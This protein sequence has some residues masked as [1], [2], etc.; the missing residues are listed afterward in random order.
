MSQHPRFY[1]SLKATLSRINS[2]SSESSGVASLS[3]ATPKNLNRVVDIEEDAQSCAEVSCEDPQWEVDKLFQT[4]RDAIVITDPQGRYLRANAAAMILFGGTIKELLGRRLVDFLS[5]EVDFSQ[6][7]QDWQVQGWISGETKLRR[8][9]GTELFVDYSATKDFLPGF[10]LFMLRDIT[11]RKRSAAALL[12]SERK[13]RAVSEQATEGIYWYDADTSLL[14]EANP[15]FCKMIGYTQAEIPQLR[16]FQFVID[17][18]ENL[19]QSLQTILTKKSCFLGK[20]NYRRRDGSLLV[21]EVNATL[22]LEENRRLICCVVRD[23]ENLSQQN[24]WYAVIENMPMMMNALDDN[25]NFIAWNKECERVTGYS[26]AEVINNPGAIKLFYPDPQYRQTMLETWQETGNSFRDW[27]LDITCKDGTV[28][29]IAW[30]NL[31]E[32]FPVVGWATWAVGLDV[33]AYKHSAKLL[34]ESQRRFHSLMENLPCAA[35]RCDYYPPGTMWFISKYI[36]EISG[37]PASDF[38]QD[39][40]RTFSSIIHP[41]DQPGAAIRLIGKTETEYSNEYRIITANA[42]IKWVQE[43]GS[44][45]CDE[46]GNL[47]ALEGVIYDITDRREMELALGS[48]L[49][50]F[51]LIAQSAFDGIWDVALPPHAFQDLA[52][53]SYLQLPVYYSPRF[54]QSL[55]YSGQEFPNILDSWFSRVHPEDIEP[56]LQAIQ[57]HLYS[58]KSLQNI[59]YRLLTQAG[60]YRWYRAAGQAI[61]NEQG[62][63]IRMAGSMRDITERKQIEREVQLQHHR[64][65]LMAAIAQRI[66]QSLDLEEILETTAAEIKQFLGVEWVAIYQLS[67]SCQGKCGAAIAA[68]SAH[69]PCDDCMA[70]CLAPQIPLAGASPLENRMEETRHSEI[71]PLATVKSLLAA[72]DADLV[73]PISILDSQNT[74]HPSQFNIGSQ[75][76][77]QIGRQIKSKQEGFT[78]FWGLIYC[79]YH[80]ALDTRETWQREFLQRLSMQLAIAI[81]QSQLYAR[82]KQANQEL[83]RLAAIDGL[84]Q[85]WNRRYFDE[86]LEREWWR[87]RREQQYLSLILC[88]VDFFKTYNDTYGHPAG[89]QVLLQISQTMSQTTKRSTDLVARYGGEEFGLILPDTDAQGAA[90]VAHQIRTAIYNLQI[91][92][93]ASPLGFVTISLGVTTVL[94]NADRY[95]TELMNTTDQALYTAKAQGRNR[96]FAAG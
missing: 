1:Q 59:E 85:V 34:S 17:Q 23:T 24:P 89:D 37:Y 21:V 2:Q 56:L 4:M 40:E 19:R 55:G 35:Y 54:R 72:N 46:E 58:K 90:V 81:Q 78:H 74:A 68:N 6:E 50:R 45:V 87:C 52:D 22:V 91:P 51:S 84:T 39:R 53:T 83:A 14:V 9:D 66:R 62:Q 88:D 77:G 60:E 38:L 49:D 67:T 64:D 3:F 95:L 70:I 29:T 73:I 18:Q 26:A 80:Q 31:S 25:L 69:F 5:P 30:S 36:E 93:R 10:D 76:G 44:A 86:C 15:A 20:H 41:E 8:L 33:T 92:H 11:E 65:Q 79:H 57:D 27:Q 82:I 32:Q 47:F 96:V 28:K 75:I 16:I 61:W 63:P 48:S 43:R 12:A 94:P 42:Q 7:W 71:L 13:Y